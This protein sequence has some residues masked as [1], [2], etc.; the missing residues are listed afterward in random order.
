MAFMYMLTFHI[1]LYTFST[2][3]VGELDPVQIKISDNGGGISKDIQDKIFEPYFTTK[4]KDG[5]GIGLYMSKVII[6]KHFEGKL[7]Y[8]TSDQFT[9]F[10]IKIKYEK[11]ESG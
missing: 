7:F 5:T 11:G 9:D 2:Q 10:I 6:E 1:I 3:R 4:D 8:E